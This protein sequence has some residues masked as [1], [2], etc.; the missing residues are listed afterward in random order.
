MLV[1]RRHVARLDGMDESG[2]LS[3]KV[4]DSAGEDKIF[5]P[6]PVGVCSTEA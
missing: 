6:V 5:N 1:T 4:E 2:G 3:T